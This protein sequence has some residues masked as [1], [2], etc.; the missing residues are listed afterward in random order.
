MICN[1]HYLYSFLQ[2]KLA[3][4][5]ESKCVLSCVLSEFDLISAQKVRLLSLALKRLGDNIRNGTDE[6]QAE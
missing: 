2:R 1:S 3:L 5:L 6:M 4:K